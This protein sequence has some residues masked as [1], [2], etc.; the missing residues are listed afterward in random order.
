MTTGERKYK[1]LA[2]MAAEASGEKG[3]ACPRCGGRASR[4]VDDGVR[5]CA[6]CGREFT[7]AK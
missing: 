7:V 2:K 3:I 5:L 1:T 4:E 6:K